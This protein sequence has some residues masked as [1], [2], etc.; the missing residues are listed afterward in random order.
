MV[1]NRKQISKIA[2]LLMTFSAIFNFPNIINNSI[3]IGLANISGYLFSTV[4]Y[5]IPI[6]FIVAEFI[7]INKDSESG[8]YSWIKTSLGDKWAFLGAWSYF[9][10]NLFYFTS[11]IPNTL[12]YASYTLFG[13][14]L[15]DGKSSTFILA[16]A[17]VILFWIGTY[18]SIKGVKVLSKVT[19]IAGIAKILMGILFIILAF[20]FV[21]F[22][23]NPPAQEFTVETLTPKFDWT[24]F[25]VL[26]MCLV[27]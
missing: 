8:I 12:I 25:Y 5:F 3:Q 1:N 22:M 20:V 21:F 6:T 18:V 10:A 24:F 7:S 14:N 4:V 17:S 23:K 27:F 13:R 9:F 15:F 26:G 11:L 16:L 2:L 19:N